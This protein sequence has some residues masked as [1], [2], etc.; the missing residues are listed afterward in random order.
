MLYGIQ[1]R[2]R[3]NR[4]LVQ[5]K[6]RRGPITATTSAKRDFQTGFFT[7]KVNNSA[8]SISEIRVLVLL[9]PTET[10]ANTSGLEYEEV[11]Y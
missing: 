2:V 6:D 4:P 10:E 9:T 3:L 8:L 11:H 5:P 1:S 7:F